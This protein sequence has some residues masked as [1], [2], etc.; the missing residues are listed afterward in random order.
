MG[1]RKQ[2]FGYKMELGEIVICLPEAVLVKHIFAQYLDGATFTTLTTELQ[3]QPVVYDEGKLWNKNMVARI[4]QDTRYTGTSGFPV[5][6]DAETLSLAGAVRSSKQAPIQ[7]TETQKLLRRLS[8]QT[9]TAQLERQVLTALNELTENPDR[10]F[11][12]QTENVESPEVLRLRRELDARMVCQPIDECAAK[13]RIFALA[14]AQYSSVNDCEYE[15][16]RLRRVFAKRKQTDTLDVELLRSS[17][18]I[19]L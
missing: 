5:I 19:P 7:K 2:P 15:T 17:V 6:I 4:L 11:L 1:N 8:G 9:A 10:I 16:I 13:T 18:S 14:A 12:P 3:N